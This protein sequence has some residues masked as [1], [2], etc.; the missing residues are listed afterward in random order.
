MTK[1]N[2]GIYYFHT[3][4]NQAVKQLEQQILHDLFIDYYTIIMHRAVTKQNKMNPKRL[5]LKTKEA[6]KM[7]CII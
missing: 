5:V 3:V 6:V 2:Y 1:E 7:A 4:L